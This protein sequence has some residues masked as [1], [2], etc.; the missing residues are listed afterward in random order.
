MIKWLSS[1][2][3]LGDHPFPHCFQDHSLSRTTFLTCLI[4]PYL[5]MPF[6]VCQFILKCW[7]RAYPP[8]S[9]ICIHS[10]NVLTTSSLSYPWNAEG[11]G[12]GALTLINW[13][14]DRS[15]L[16]RL[17]PPVLRSTSSSSV[18]NWTQAHFFYTIPNTDYLAATPPSLTFRLSCCHHLVTQ[19]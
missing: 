5:S 19:T 13:D 16:D 12:N 1:A 7:S 2:L 17:H 15:H 9:L 8:T 11:R 3:P 18:S 14:K 10:L 6:F 4:S